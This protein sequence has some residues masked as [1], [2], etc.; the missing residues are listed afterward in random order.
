MKAVFNHFDTD[1]SGYITRENIK[2]ALSKIGH[3]VT[4][5]EIMEMIR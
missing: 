4:E 1:S 3:N 5:E 2:E